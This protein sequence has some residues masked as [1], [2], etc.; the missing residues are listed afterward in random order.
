MARAALTIVPV[1]SWEG[2]FR[3]KG[4]GDQL[5][6]FYHA[7]LTFE[8]LNVQCTPRENAG[9]AYEKWSPAL[10]WYGAPEWL[11]WP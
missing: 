10:R 5:P 4:G 6:N 3:R 7:I 2:P 8:R 11:I 1:V 9:Y